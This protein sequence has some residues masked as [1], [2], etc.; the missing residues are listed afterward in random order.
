MPNE[1]P[2]PRSLSEAVR[3]VIRQNEALGYCPARFRQATENGDASNLLQVCTNL[4]CSA[5]ALQALEDALGSYPELLT[6]EDLLA[7]SR[8]GA[9]WCFDETVIE[10]AEAR[11]QYFDAR[12]GYERWSQ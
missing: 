10:Q 12:V 6:L 8:Y 4:I 7:R 3:E 9:D 1:L 5:D 11:V 2:T